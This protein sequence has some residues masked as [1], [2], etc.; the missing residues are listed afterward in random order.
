MKQ[1]EP[2]HYWKELNGCFEVDQRSVVRIALAMEQHIADDGRERTFILAFADGRQIVSNQADDLDNFPF[3][4]PKRRR[5]EVHV[6]NKK[7]ESA[8]VEYRFGIS[9]ETVRVSAHA[10]SSSPVNVLRM[11]ADVADA[12]A[13]TRTW[14]SLFRP[15]HM[16]WWGL[17]PLTASFVGVNFVSHPST[18]SDLDWTLLWFIGTYGALIAAIIIRFTLFRTIETDFGAEGQRLARRKLIRGW[19]PAATGAF[20]LAI[21]GGGYLLR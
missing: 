5:F 12:V 2:T 17:I 13:A 15:M 16:S 20:V 14:Y 6:R 4:A 8:A 11:G 19:L 10:G 7:G 9:A 1:V 21:I 18:L 3:H